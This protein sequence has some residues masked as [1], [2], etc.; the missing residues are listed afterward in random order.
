MNPSSRGLHTGSTFV[1]VIRLTSVRGDHETEYRVELRAMQQCSNAAMQV[2]ES[3][4]TKQGWQVINVSR[5]RGEHGGYDLYLS[6]GEERIRVEVKGC[7]RAYGIPDP[8]HTE[9]DRDTKNLIADLLCVVYF[10]PD[11]PG[12]RIAVIPPDAIPTDCVTL[13]LGSRISS[14]FKNRDTIERFMVGTDWDS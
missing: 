13:K 8:Y 7:T 6:K 10:L 5:A 9:F 12:P 3:Y 11:T 1:T 14:R 4:F 2:A